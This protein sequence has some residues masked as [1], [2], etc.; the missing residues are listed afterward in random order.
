MILGRDEPKGLVK[1]SSSVG[2]LRMGHSPN[3]VDVGGHELVRADT[4]EITFIA[5]A[6]I[7][8]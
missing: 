7:I 5:L 3:D 4:E 6:G 1:G 2:R 8:K